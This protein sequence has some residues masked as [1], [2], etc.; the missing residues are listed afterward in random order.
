MTPVEKA[1][2]K[3]RWTREGDYLSVR[4]YE[5]SLNLDLCKKE[6]I[7]LNYRGF[8]HMYPDDS[9]EFIFHR[10]DDFK[11]FIKIAKDVIDHD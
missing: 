8:K 5:Y 2:F 7:D 6:F 11:K 1:E 3:M 9:H 10:E 4:T